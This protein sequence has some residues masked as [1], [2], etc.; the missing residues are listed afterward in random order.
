[1]DR[2]EDAEWAT[3]SSQLRIQKMSLD[4]LIVAIMVRDLKLRTEL[5]SVQ[6]IEI[7]LWSDRFTSTLKHQH[8]IRLFCTPHTLA[9]AQIL[10][11]RYPE[12]LL[13]LSQFSIALVEP[14]SALDSMPEL[15]SQG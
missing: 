14:G 13:I 4:Y 10:K 11:K 12:Q 5:G 15:A 2:L 7:A 1:M 8:E 3:N 9:K 6:A